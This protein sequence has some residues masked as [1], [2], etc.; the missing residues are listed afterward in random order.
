MAS[1]KHKKTEAPEPE[2]NKDEPI[3]FAG[4]LGIVLVAGGLFNVPA[5][6]K[7]P[8]TTEDRMMLVIVAAMIIG[9]ALLLLSRRRK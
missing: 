5:I 7:I 1:R 4:Y 8:E 6:L 2:E 9:G 3:G